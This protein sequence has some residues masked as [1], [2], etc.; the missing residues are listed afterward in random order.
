MIVGISTKTPVLPNSNQK[1]IFGHSERSEESLFS[2]RRDS[3]L[4]GA[5]FRMT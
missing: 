5:P 3:S 1:T 2:S 4:R